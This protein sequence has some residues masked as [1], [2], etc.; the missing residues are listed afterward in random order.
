MNLFT[1]SVLLGIAMQVVFLLRD[2][3]RHSKLDAQSRRTLRPG[4][5]LGLPNLRLISSINSLAPFDIMNRF[6]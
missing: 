2:L 6:A 3:E 1:S 5:F 4:E